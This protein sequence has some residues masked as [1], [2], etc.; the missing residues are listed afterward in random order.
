[1]MPR[2]SEQFHLAPSDIWALTTDELAAYSDAA[3]ATDAANAEMERRY[4]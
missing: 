1:M 4:G 2:L 3:A